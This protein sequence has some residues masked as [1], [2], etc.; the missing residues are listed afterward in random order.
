MNKERENNGAR[1]VRAQLERKGEN[2]RFGFY[3]GSQGVST[4]EVVT[5]LGDGGK[6]RHLGGKGGESTCVIPAEDERK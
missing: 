1:G 6:W 4:V 5:C 3:D 2:R